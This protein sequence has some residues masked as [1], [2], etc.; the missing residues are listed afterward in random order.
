MAV[1]V[2]ETQVLTAGLAALCS[3][4]Y[5]NT[6]NQERIGA[7]PGAVDCVL[8]GMAAHV[9]EADVQGNGMMT[10][11]VLALNN[12]GNQHQMRASSPLLHLLVFSAVGGRGGG[13]DGGRYNLYDAR[14]GRGAGEAILREL[15]MSVAQARAAATKV[16]PT[17]P[18]DR[19][20]TRLNSSPQIGRA[21]V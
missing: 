16:R 7:T 19:K 2:D 6:P 15:G 9:G 17:R 3:L 5:D 11:G 18:P 21:H 14:H 20:S 10:L 12:V 4:A 8:A 1:H 13:G